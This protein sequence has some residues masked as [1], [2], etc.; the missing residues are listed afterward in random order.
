MN[1]LN[2][3]IETDSLTGAHHLERLDSAE[4]AYIKAM[5]DRA[6]RDS[7]ANLPSSGPLINIVEKHDSIQN[8]HVQVGKLKT[9]YKDNYFSNS[10]FYTEAKASNIDG[11][12]GDP[13]HYH[14]MADDAITTI[15]LM[16]FFLLSLVFASGKR[17]LLQQIKEFNVVRERSSIFS[18]HSGSELRFQMFLTCQTIFILAVLFFDYT[19]DTFPEVFQNTSPYVLLGINT[20]VCIAYFFFKF[21]IYSFVNWVFFERQRRRIWL[22]SYWLVVSLAGLVMFPLLLLIVYFDLSIKNAFIYLSVSWILSKLMLFY[23]AY[24]IFFSKK[25]GILYLIMYFCALELM[26]AAFL[27]QALV[28]ANNSLIIKN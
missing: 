10:E 24:S 14:L 25:G 7:M 26:P 1:S 20:G 13:V 4:L 3:N 23:K 21:S 22:E 16:C 9:Y 28:L 12:S 17:F 6:Y 11:M 15:V 5:Q 27:W 8:L 19:M 18:I 2:P